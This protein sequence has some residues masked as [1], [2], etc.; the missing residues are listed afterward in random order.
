MNQLYHNFLNNVWAFD[1]IK[2]TDEDKKR[3]KLYKENVQREKYR[4]SVVSLKDFLDGLK[5]QIKISTP[6]TE[7]LVRVSQLTF[8]TNQFNFTTIRRTEAE[9]KTLLNSDR[10]SLFNNRG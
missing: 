9:V 10:K 3:T 5:L 2:L 1:H 8:R 7:Q 6:T 4:E